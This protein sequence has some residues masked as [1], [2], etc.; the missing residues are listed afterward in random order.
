MAWD[1]KFVS[2]ESFRVEHD[3]LTK[4]QVREAQGSGSLWYF[5]YEGRGL[6]KEF[7]LHKSPRVLLDPC[8]TLI[9]KEHHF[10]PRLR[11][12]KRK[13][14]GVSPTQETLDS[15]TST[16]VKASVDISEGRD[17]FWKVINYLRTLTDVDVPHET[18]HVA[19]GDIAEVEALLKQQTKDDVVAAVRSALAG[20]LTEAD[21]DLLADRKRHLETFAR[22][23]SDDAFFDEC[24]QRA[25]GPEDVWQKF[26]KRNQWIFGYGLALISCEALDGEKLER[27]TSGANIFTGAG[28]RIDAVMRTQG[29]IKS[30]IFAEIKTHRKELLDEKAYR[31]P[32]VYRVTKEV[33]GS[34]AQVQKSSDK[35]VRQLQQIIR[36][37]Y[38]D[39]GDYTGVDVAT[40]RPRQVVV[41]G[42]LS[43][44]RGTAR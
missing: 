41:I 16:S 11:F 6:V 38:D 25:D 30:L 43:S 4:L 33:T 21:L 10:E 44:S 3:D 15:S 22:L 29:Y 26:F 8:D 1:F 42:Q 9:R 14:G 40:V 35:A 39:K 24:V 20:Q 7:I 27:Y 32:D 5:Y 17:S 23:L 37:M 13:T 36:R 31:E 12:S 19:A 18:F 2:P 34:V 28:K